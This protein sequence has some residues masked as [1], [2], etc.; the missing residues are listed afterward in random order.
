M[1]SLGIDIDSYLAV[2]PVICQLITTGTL[3]SHSSDSVLTAPVP[4]QVE[5]FSTLVN[6]RAV[7]LRAHFKPLVTNTPVASKQINTSSVP[8]NTRTSDTLV[9][10]HALVFAGGQGEPIVTAALETT[11]HVGA[12][13]V[14]ADPSNLKTL[15]QV[16]AVPASDA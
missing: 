9:H 8:T 10:V 4:T 2:T 12:L 5:I 16:P 6:I 3:A 1:L 13:P 14:V 11:S 15:V 7:A